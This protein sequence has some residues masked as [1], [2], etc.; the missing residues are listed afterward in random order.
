[1]KWGLN[2]FFISIQ[3]FF[4]INFISY[5]LSARETINLSFTKLYPQSSLKNFFGLTMRLWT[6]VQELKKESH[7]ELNHIFMAH[8]AQEVLLLNTT[9][10]M[11]L[12]ETINPTQHNNGQESMLE[13]V[14]YLTSIIKEL[15]SDYTE[16]VKQ[17]TEKHVVCAVSLFTLEAILKKLTLFIKE[18]TVLPALERLAHHSIDITPLSVPTMMYP[19]APIPC[20]QYARV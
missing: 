2:L 1:M 15:L 16:V 5:S 7:K 10:D 9:V 6:T 8:F 3:L 20:T 4:E 19:E 12:I 17:Y 13:N 18:G 14:E 11:M